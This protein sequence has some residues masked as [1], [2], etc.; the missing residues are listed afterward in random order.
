[1]R[2]PDGTYDRAGAEAEMRKWLKSDS[3]DAMLRDHFSADYDA[4]VSK[5]GN[6][7]ILT[8]AH[9]CPAA[10][11]GPSSCSIQCPEIVRNGAVS[12]NYNVSCARI[13]ADGFNQ[14][15][16]GKYEVK[17]EIENDLRV[18]LNTYYPTT[19]WRDHSLGA[20]FLVLKTLERMISLL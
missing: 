15:P 16:S 4:M 5:S 13:Y 17:L 3:I 6:H 19:L 10:V 8:I 12:Y 7:F 18:F 9:G 1:M 2:N 20:Q 14:T 11:T